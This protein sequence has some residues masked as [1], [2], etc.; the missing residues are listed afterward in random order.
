MNRLIAWW[1]NNPI[2]ANL[3][4]IG[5]LLAGAVGF[6]NMEREA[7]PMFN[8]SRVAIEVAWPGAAPQEVEEQ[9]IIRMEQALTSLATV[10]LIYA[11]AEEGFGRLEIHSYPSIAIDAFLDEVK[12]TIDA[13]TGLP[14]DIE[15]PRV[16]RVQFRQEM[17]RVAVHGDLPERQ[18]NRFARTLR[19]EMQSLPYVSLVELFG[20][21]REEVSIELSETALRRY[22]LTFGEVAEAIRA[23]SVNVSGGSIRTQTGDVLLRA[24]NLADDQDDFSRIVIR[25]TEGG[26]IIRV[27]DVARV[28][29]GFE[30]EEILATLNGQSAVLLQAMTPDTMQVVK[31]SDAVRA[32]M[33]ERE[34]T[35]PEGVSLSIWFDT[36]DIYKSRMGTIAAHP[37]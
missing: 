28:V 30:D 36:A 12:N 24:R 20:T 13:V 14:R 1:A 35:L 17:I 7:F 31:S 16:R 2:A 5:I 10:R 6:N 21:R 9:I 3:L 32:W 8:T 29:D 4:M 27:G 18:L 11:T 37:G 26:G 25:Q 22:G 33:A 19:D 23:S 34:R 15:P